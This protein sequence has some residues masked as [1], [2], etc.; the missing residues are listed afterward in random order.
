MVFLLNFNFSGISG[1]FRQQ[2]HLFKKRAVQGNM[3]IKHT[4]IF[5]RLQ[6]A[7]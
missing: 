4:L 6:A 5:N 2:T 7:Q 3:V 1:G